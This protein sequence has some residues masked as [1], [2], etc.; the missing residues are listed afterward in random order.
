MRKGITI[1][2]ELLRVFRRNEQGEEEDVSLQMKIGEGKGNPFGWSTAKLICML[3]VDGFTIDHEIGE[4]YCGDI[5]I[6]DP[7]YR[8][9]DPDEDEDDG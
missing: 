4:H 7:R 3:S 1:D 5:T 9:I 6:T 2:G 8:V